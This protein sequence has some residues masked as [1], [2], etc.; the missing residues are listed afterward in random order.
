M[1]LNKLR[2]S[3]EVPIRYLNITR[4]KDAPAAAVAGSSEFFNDDI[5]LPIVLKL[6]SYKDSC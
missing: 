6:P 5:K 1:T 2:K 4:T 3:V